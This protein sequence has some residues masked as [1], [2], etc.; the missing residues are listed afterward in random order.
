MEF[1]Q[2][3]VRRLSVYSTPGRAMTHSPG[4]LIDS[5][6]TAG[7]WKRPTHER[8]NAR[9]QTAEAAADCSVAWRLLRFRAALS[10]VVLCLWGRSDAA[11]RQDPYNARQPRASTKTV[12]DNYNL[13]SHKYVCITTYQPDTKSNPNPNPNPNLIPNPTMKQHTIVNIQLNIVSC[14]TSPGK[15]ILDTLLHFLC[16]F[17]L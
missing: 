9:T 17:R 11:A 5:R 16:D 3:G 4:R 10:A 7:R 13:K 14:P 1:W 2:V 8:T 15:F 12:C 6:K